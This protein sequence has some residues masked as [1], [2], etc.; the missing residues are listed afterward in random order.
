[1]GGERERLREFSDQSSQPVI[2][3]G[4]SCGLVTLPQIICASSALARLAVLIPRT[5]L[6]LT[7]NG[8]N[9]KALFRFLTD[10]N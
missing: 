10:T 8:A 3:V 4:S 1:M 5:L 7:T 6:I 9:I 2:K